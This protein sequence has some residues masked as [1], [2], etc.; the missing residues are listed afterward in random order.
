MALSETFFRNRYLGTVKKL[1]YCQMFNRNNIM[2]SIGDILRS[3]L[4]HDD[5]P[6]TATIIL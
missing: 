4:Y 6:S 3:L 2:T 5:S 1:K